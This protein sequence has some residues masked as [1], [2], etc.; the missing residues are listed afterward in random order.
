MC[1]P[2]IGPKGL[3]AWQAIIFPAHIT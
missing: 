1:G 2:K 3:M